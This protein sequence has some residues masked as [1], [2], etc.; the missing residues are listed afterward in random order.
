MSG[1]F[2]KFLSECCGIDYLGEDVTIEY[3]HYEKVDGRNT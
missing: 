1:C 3:Q 2:R